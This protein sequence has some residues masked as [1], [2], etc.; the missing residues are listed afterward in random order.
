MSFERHNQGELNHLIEQREGN[1]KFTKG[2]F[3]KG[4]KIGNWHAVEKREQ[5]AKPLLA[6]LLRRA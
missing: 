3:R 2:Y 1:S 5:K 6:G 4:E